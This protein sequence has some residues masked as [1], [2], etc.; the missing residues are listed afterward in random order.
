MAVEASL[1]KDLFKVEMYILKVIPMIMAILHL[2]STILFFFG[3]DLEILSYIGGISFLTLGFLYL[4]SY[5]FRFC[6]YHRLFLHYVT[7]NNIISIYDTY[8]GIPVSDSSL[9]ITNM[10]IAGIFLFFILYFKIYE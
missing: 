2:L 1:N 5:V 7:V 4:S 6:I 10:I 8:V 9:F 3:I